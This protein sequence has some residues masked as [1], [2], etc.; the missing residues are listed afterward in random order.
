M[1]GGQGDAAEADA[2][3]LAV[4]F[5]H[6]ESDNVAR[7]TANESGSYDSVGLLTDLAHTS[8][9]L[10]TSI[11]ADLAFR[12]YSEDAIEDETVGTL[13]AIADIDLVR[14]VFSW[15]LRED[16][17]Q[18]RRDLFSP[19]GPNNRESINV[20]ASGPQIDV[21]LGGRTTLSIGGD[22]SV[23]RYDE[24]TNV[25]SDATVYEL[26]LFRRTT[27]TS[28]VGLVATSDEVEYTDVNA[29]PYD[30]NRVT[31]RYD[32]ALATGRVF[33]DI[34]SN[35]ITYGNFQTDEPLIVFEWSRALT[36]RSHLNDQRRPPI[37]RFRQSRRA[38]DH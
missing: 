4:W 34:G 38:D 16:Y 25:D 10:E 5:G 20:I 7:T 13:A 23:R 8:T 2:K 17:S 26:G 24:S 18:G 32:K 35:E 37:H 12:T 31:L 28:V 30:I 3:I 9:R 33:A 29:P 6:V 1:L 14:D 27:G 15:D 11:K 19:M 21:P 22:Y 36:A